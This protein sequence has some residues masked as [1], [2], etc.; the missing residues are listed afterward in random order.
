MTAMTQESPS[1]KTTKVQETHHAAR[2]ASCE[3]K[4]IFLLT[5][6]LFLPIAAL[7]RLLP[8]AWRP[9]AGF[10]DA[11]EGIYCEARRAADIV[12]PCVFMG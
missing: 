6:L 12:I 1:I 3:Y 10:S 11:K 8:R 5:M 4:M 9:L 7:S 2:R